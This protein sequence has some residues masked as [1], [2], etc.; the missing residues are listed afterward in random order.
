VTNAIHL[1]YMWSG[2]FGVSNVS[3]E[4]LSVKLQDT[5][6]FFSE[7]KN[8]FWFQN[9]GW[10]LFVVKKLSGALVQGHIVLR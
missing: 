9:Q 7:K 2:L 5:S 4:C 8:T 1:V 10:I 3:D 6:W